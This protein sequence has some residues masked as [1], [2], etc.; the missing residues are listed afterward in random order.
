MVE[1]FDVI[2]V[3]AGPAGIAC[4][5]TLA[6]AGLETVVLERG[7][8]PGAK[9]VIGGILFTTVLNKLIPGLLEEAPLERYLVERKF[10]LLSRDTEL[11]FSFRTEKF[12]QPPHNNSFTVLRA[13]FDRWFAK[14]TEGIGVM[15]LPKVMVD[16]I[17]WEKTKCVGVRTR[18]NGDE[19]YAD[20][21][22]LAEGANSV[23]A[24]KD[25]LKPVSDER[26]MA[27]AVKE[28]ISLPQ[29]VIENRFH[30]SDSKDN[31][32]IPEG[33]AIEYFGDAVK[34]MFGNAF[35]YTNKD[36]LSVG[37]GC[38]LD[39]LSR[40][41][42][43]PHDILEY[44]KSHPC[45][46]S[47]LRDGKT[48]EYSAHMIPEGGYNN[49]PKLVFDGL[50]LIGDCAGFVNTSFFHEGTNLAMASGVFAAEAIIEAKRKRGFSCEIL[51]SYEKK[52][53]KSFI[54]EDMKKF[55]NFP[56]LGE[57]CP[58]LLSKYPEVFAE[59]IT[60][61]FTVGEKSKK[62][63]EH[64]VI[65]KFK[66]KLGTLKFSRNMLSVAKAMGWI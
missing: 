50:M 10:S 58:E 48:E 49:V 66:K 47:L 7:E 36:S 9:N 26:N 8:Y 34:G 62:N 21:V 11:S 52:V 45:V 17:I 13:K 16:E 3:G 37:V 27:I 39:E 5:Y 25:G 55:R 56:V 19:L 41:N 29:K 46:S 32:R 33:T 43:N 15:I 23:L 22:V 18:L 63:I 57:E 14:K 65:K 44:F 20:V 31:S 30:L 35:I 64:E 61:Y 4:A 28:I 51:S 1:K 53:Q 2:I 24:E 54:I 12:S 60:D 42:M 59:I 6:R 40:K 38:T